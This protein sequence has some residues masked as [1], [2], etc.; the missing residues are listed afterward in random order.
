MSLR[1]DFGVSEAQSRPRDSLPAVYGST[2][3]TLCLNAAMFPI[4]Q[5]MDCKTVSKPQLSNFFFKNCH[6]HST[7]SLPSNRALIAY[8][9]MLVN[10][11]TI[12]VD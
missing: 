4:M 11:L 8:F 2:C 5:K 12:Y 1:V 6:G 10:I 9:D 7:V 3:R